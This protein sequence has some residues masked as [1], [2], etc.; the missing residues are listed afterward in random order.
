M[1]EPVAYCQTHHRQVVNYAAPFCTAYQ[2][3]TKNSCVVVAGMVLTGDDLKE[4]ADMTIGSAKE[5]L[6]GGDFKRYAETVLDV[7]SR[8]NVSPQTKGGLH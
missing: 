7:D 2:L 4:Y 1:R 6:T 8:S 5:S 3:H